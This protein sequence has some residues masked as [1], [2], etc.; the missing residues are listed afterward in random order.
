MLLEE[1]ERLNEQLSNFVK[2]GMRLNEMISKNE[3]MIKLSC[4]FRFFLMYP[5]KVCH[6]FSFNVMNMAKKVNGTKN[7]TNAMNE[8][9]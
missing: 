8:L 9:I 1:I 5:Q 4:F 3:C 7:S 2:C 6:I